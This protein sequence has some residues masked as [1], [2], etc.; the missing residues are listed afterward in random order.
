M[1]LRVLLADESGTIKRVIQLALQDYA[2]EVKSVPI[3][4][5]VIPVAKTFHPDIVFADILLPKRNGYEVCAD[6]KA[7]PETKKI[8]VILMWS[9]FMEL[10]QSKLKECHANGQLEKPFET[11][12][13]RSL[14]QSLVPRIQ[15]QPMSAFLKFPRLPEFDEPSKSA[16]ASAQTP[17]EENFQQIPLHKKEAP[18]SIPSQIPSFTLNLD[19]PEAA[20]TELQA[21]SDWAKKDLSQFKL[22]LPEPEEIKMD[23]IPL[24]S[25]EEVV[26][27]APSHSVAV[28]SALDMAMT[29]KILREEAQKMLENLVWKILPEITERVVQQEINKLLQESEKSI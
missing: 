23:A 7:D 3:G 1:A 6:L 14:V 26:F 10:D 29:E 5:D 25:F 19:D 20:E 18:P 21:D 28:P 24:E 12:Q 9:G 22:K 13:L 8:P 27:D 2:V 15:T 16:Q 11:E 17:I 4:L